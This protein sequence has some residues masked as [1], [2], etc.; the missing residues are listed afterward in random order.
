[1]IFFTRDPRD[2]LY[3]QYKRENLNLSFTEFIS[4]PN[5]STLLDKAEFLRLFHLCWMD[6]QDFKVFRFEDYKKDAFSTLKAI[7]DSVGLSA[8]Q[9][10]I[11]DAVSASTFEK[12]ATAE[13]NYRKEHPEDPERINRSASIHEWKSDPALKEGIS[14]IERV[15]WDLLEKFGYTAPG[16]LTPRRPDYSIHLCSVPF[17]R[18]MHIDPNLYVSGEDE[19]ESLALGV[20]RFAESLSPDLLR[21]AALN[22]KEIT[23][24]LEN[25]GN[26]SRAFS[27][28]YPQHLDLLA[29]EFLGQTAL[30]TTFRV[31]KSRL[32]FQRLWGKI[33]KK[34]TQMGGIC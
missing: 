34:N 26:F 12:A 28:K 11:T 7:L 18:V 33:F 32:I 14:H 15:C 9:K 24:L 16:A 10:E 17:F 3:S 22:R 23:F 20:C 30:F 25:L 2:C 4:F 19:P 27:G 29:S 6:F 8:S 1:M 31:S 13:A 5:P 21:R